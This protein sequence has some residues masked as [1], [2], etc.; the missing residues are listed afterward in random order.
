MRQVILRGWI[1]LCLAG[2]VGCQTPGGAGGLLGGRTG[3]ASGSC[4]P[5][6]A[7]GSCEVQQPGRAMSM[8]PEDGANM[9]WYNGKPGGSSGFLAGLH[10]RHF[11]GHQSHMGSQP[12]PAMGPPSPT[13]T[14]PYYTTRGPRDYLAK[15]PPSIGR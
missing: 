9:A 6:C 1:G 15:N 7:S 8:H 10:G 3:C 4:G 12:G 13:V 14:Y 2:L 11:R 5:M